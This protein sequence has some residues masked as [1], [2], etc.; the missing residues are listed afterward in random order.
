MAKKEKQINVVWLILIGVALF[1]LLKPDFFKIPTKEFSTTGFQCYIGQTE[2]YTCPDGSEYL[3][4]FCDNED[5]LCVPDPAEF[6]IDR[7]WGDVTNDNSGNGNGNGGGIIPPNIPDI[8][9]YVWWIV[10]GVALLFIIKGLIR[11]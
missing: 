8:P 5:W 7:G 9:S 3:N 6:C 2:Y 1:F 11:R 4:C 10:G